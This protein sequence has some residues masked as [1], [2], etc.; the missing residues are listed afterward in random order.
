M[1]ILS[2]V[3]VDQEVPGCDECGSK[4]LVYVVMMDS[5]CEVFS[6]VAIVHEIGCK[7]VEPDSAETEQS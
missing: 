7:Q 3:K 2:I 5:E 4:L 1:E 6:D